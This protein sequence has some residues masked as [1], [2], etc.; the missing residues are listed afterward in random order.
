MNQ[1]KNKRVNLIGYLNKSDFNFYAVKSFQ[2]GVATHEGLKYFSHVQ[3][4]F[5]AN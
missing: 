5:P 3:E 4:H 2:S 1:M